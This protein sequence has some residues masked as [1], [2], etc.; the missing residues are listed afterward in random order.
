LKAPR[1]ADELLTETGAA[2]TW[3]QRDDVDGF[4]VAAL[5]KEA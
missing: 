2:R 5:E 1:V 4:F 3:P